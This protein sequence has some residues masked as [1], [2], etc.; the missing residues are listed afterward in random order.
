MARTLAIAW[1]LWVIILIL[2]LVFVAWLVIRMRARSS[3]ARPLDQNQ[4]ADLP[5]PEPKIHLEQQL[6]VG[7]P[8]PEHLVEIEGPEKLADLDPS[9]FTDN[10]EGDDLKLVRGITPGIISVLHAAGIRTLTQLAEMTPEQLEKILRAAGM[11]KLNSASWPEQARLAA[12]GDWTGLKNF[13]Q[14][15]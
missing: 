10:N 11:R 8:V 14:R 2:F 6:P 15:L 13:Q 1:W 9:L 4:P 12:E 7:P 3:T 5:E